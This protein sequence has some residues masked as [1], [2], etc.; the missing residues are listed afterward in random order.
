LFEAA[1]AASARH[2]EGVE[3][4]VAIAEADAEHEIAAPDRVERGNGLGDLD[5]V[6]QSGQQHAGNAGHLACFGGEPRQKRH[7]LDLPH[8]FAEVMLAGC[9]CIP[10]AVARQARHRILAFQGRDHVAS[11]RL[12]TGEKNP[13]LH[14]ASSAAQV[15]S[16]TQ[17]VDDRRQRGN[18]GETCSGELQ[19]ERRCAARLLH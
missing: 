3:L 13:D 4:D 19:S 11:G 14:D 8:P 7:E 6:V 9:D 16:T 1:H 10:A 12:L 2:A 17:V 18:S 5:R 15:A